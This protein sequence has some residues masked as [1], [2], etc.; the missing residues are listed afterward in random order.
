MTGV[1]GWM[2]FLL[3]LVLAGCGGGGD[4][5]TGGSSGGG[6]S[7]GG[8]SGE[9]PGGTPTSPSPGASSPTP[10]VDPTDYV[11]Q[12]TATPAPGGYAAGYRARELG[13][14]AMT[15]NLISGDLIV[16][17]DVLPGQPGIL[18]L[19][20]VSLA[21]RWSMP[22]TVPGD[23]VAISDDGS[24]LFVGMCA[25]YGI[26]QIDLASRTEERFISL[27]SANRPICATSLSVRPHHPKQVA[28]A[29]TIFGPLVPSPAGIL[30]FDDGQQ[31]PHHASTP[32]GFVWSVPGRGFTDAALLQFQSENVLVGKTKYIDPGQLH[33]YEVN[34]QGVTVARVDD[35]V[36][37][38]ATEFRLAN[39]RVFFNTGSVFSVANPADQAYQLRNC[40]WSPLSSTFTGVTAT[41][42]AICINSVLQTQRS[43]PRQVEID[44]AIVSLDGERTL[45]RSRLDLRRIITIPGLATPEVDIVDVLGL[46]D[47]TIEL[48]VYDYQSSRLLLVSVSEGELAETV[49]PV[50]VTGRVARNG[51]TV[52][53]MTLPLL[54]KA[55]DATR[56]RLVGVT[57]GSWGS[58]G[59]ALVVVEPST[60][61][62]AGSVL[63]SR[64]P[65]ALALS[66]DGQFAYVMDDSGIQ[67]IHLGTLALGWFWRTTGF[68][69][70]MA[71]RPGVSGQIAVSVAGRLVLVDGGVVV[72]QT[73]S[74]L[75]S[76]SLA[77]KDANTVVEL[78]T[79]SYAYAR[80]LLSNRFQPYVVH[81]VDLGGSGYPEIYSL[82][83]RAFNRGGQVLD[84]PSMNMDPAAP[85]LSELW[86][87]NPGTIDGFVPMDQTSFLALR[88]KYEWNSPPKLIFELWDSDAMR[89][90]FTVA[91]P[92]GTLLRSAFLP[93]RMGPRSA[94]IGQHDA[95]RGE[96]LTLFVSW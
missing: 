87:G 58:L 47:G 84:L 41:G 6:G 26:A 51:I 76:P 3:T 89:L 43:D 22:T 56:Q 71:V 91:D 57:P 93:T 86:G 42:N 15:T 18:G 88:Q 61:Q 38:S 32:N 8:S 20:P 25:R 14:H 2:T 74:A 94:A 50:P 30:M 67:Q 90:D 65:R 73:P 69:S 55:F 33:I 7:T 77:F 27:G 35:W 52:D 16:V 4:S 60:M 62:I 54:A 48:L 92:G 31:L 10:G 95:T 45:R 64:E 39:G 79:G 9:T 49:S 13:A 21:T 23:T 11:L 34:D 24:K 72:D 75:S 85:T 29:L 66:E 78:T 28:V 82:G 83:Q 12:R 81:V 36:G 19:D 53:W 17:G 46:P 40:R 1:R 63:L 70:A 80:A 44:V 68:V 59:S 37:T 5:V 96:G